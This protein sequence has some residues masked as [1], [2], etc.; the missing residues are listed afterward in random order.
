MYLGPHKATFFFRPDPF[1]I[2]QRQFSPEDLFYPH[3]LF[4]ILIFITAAQ[5]KETRKDLFTFLLFNFD[6]VLKTMTLQRKGRL[7]KRG[8]EGKEER[9]NV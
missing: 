1:T 4:N 9:S 8:K 3:I 5:W 2:R 6:N 7:E